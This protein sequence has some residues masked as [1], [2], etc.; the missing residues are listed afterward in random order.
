VG[1]NSIFAALLAAAFMMASPSGHAE[2]VTPAA[3]KMLRDLDL[4]TKTLDGTAA[5]LAVPQ[6]WLD[7][8]KKEGAVVIYDTINPQQWSKIYSVFSARYPD[9]KIDHSEVNTSTRRYILP[10]TAFDQGRHLVDIVAGISGNVFMFRQ[11]KALEDLSDLPNYSAMPAFARQ[12]DNITVT[13]RIQYWCMSYNTQLLKSEDLPKTWDDL[14]TDKA[15]AGN[16]LMIGNRP[17]DWLLYLWQ[18]KGSAWGER[19]IRQLFANLHPQL[20]KESLNALVNLVALGEGKAATPQTMDKVGDAVRV[21]SPVGYH[22]PEPAPMALT[23]MGLF[24]NSPHA[25]GARIFMNW[26]ISK[27]GQIAQYWANHSIPARAD[28]QDKR[29]LDFPDAVVGKKVATLTPASSQAAIELSAA[30][31]KAWQSGGD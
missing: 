22:C 9:I 8:A 23:E 24:K 4:D 21:G 1:S 5:E 11:A 13:T 30:W 15:L 7:G 10:L 18:S 17:N 3:Q 28:L 2:T 26:F 20:R 29:F 16:S 14:V 19:Y 31:D 6:A 12:P 25:D 27:E